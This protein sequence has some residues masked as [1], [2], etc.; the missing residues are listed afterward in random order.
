MQENEVE[1]WSRLVAPTT[2]QLQGEKLA[3]PIFVEHGSPKKTPRQW[4]FRYAATDSCF[5]QWITTES[6]VPAGTLT[7]SVYRPFTACRTT[8]RLA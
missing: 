2:R 6:V 4:G 3:E 5:V 8:G 7:V 1:E